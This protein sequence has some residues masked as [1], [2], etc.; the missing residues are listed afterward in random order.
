MPVPWVPAPPPA[1]PAAPAPM[2]PTA[3]LIESGGGCPDRAAAI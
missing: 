1:A 3:G 2:A